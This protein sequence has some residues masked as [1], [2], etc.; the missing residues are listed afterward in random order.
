[1]THPQIVPLVLDLVDPITMIDLQDQIEGNIKKITL[2]DW[3]IE[4][5]DPSLK[6][7]FFQLVFSHGFEVRSLSFSRTRSIC[8]NAVQVPWKGRKK[9][10]PIVRSGPIPKTFV[11]CIADSHGQDFK[12]ITRCVLWFVMELAPPST[13]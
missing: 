6:G 7:P 2:T 11:I 5:S 4:V 10:F 8:E 9:E 1:M 3:K 12:G 13:K